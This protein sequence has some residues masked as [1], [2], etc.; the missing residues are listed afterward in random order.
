MSWQIIEAGEGRLLL[1]PITDNTPTP[2]PDAEP[3]TTGTSSYCDL[4]RRSQAGTCA[5][6]AAGAAEP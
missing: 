3:F 5:D 6:I 1:W 2:G 4:E